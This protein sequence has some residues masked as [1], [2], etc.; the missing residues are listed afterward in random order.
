[1][2]Q[3]KHIVKIPLPEI[4]NLD[5]ATQKYLA[6][7]EEKLGMI[8]NVLRAYTGNVEKFHNFTTLYNTLMLDEKDCNLTKLERE[9]IAVVVSSA[10]RCYY[11]LVAHGQAVRELSNDP[12]LGEMMVMNY[13]VAELDDRTQKMLDFVWKL[14]ELPHKISDD[15]R[16]NLR[17]VGFSEQDI[18]DI[19]ETAAFFNY[20]NRMAHGLDMM[21]NAEY[22]GKNR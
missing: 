17:G 4:E 11:C 9:M 5:D 6:I 3:P 22:H 12:Q 8:P 15:D 7:C 2:P 20:T 21:P 1:M 10:N 18:F 19:C 13:R 16:Q 14:T